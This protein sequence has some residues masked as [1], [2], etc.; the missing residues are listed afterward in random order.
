VRIGLLSTP[1]VPV[2]P[3][4]YG[5]TEMV[6]GFLARGLV[7]AGHEVVV[8]GHRESAIRGV[9][10]IPAPAVPDGVTIGQVS[11]E[12]AHVLWGYR[13]LLAA[14]VDLIHDHTTAGPV[15]GARLA[16]DAGVPV[17][18]T[19]HGPFDW[20]ARELYTQA[21][22]IC[23]VVAIS[24]G[25]AIG[26]RS[27]PVSAIIHHG[28]DVEDVPVGDGSGGYL[29][30]LGRLNADKGVAR[31]A[32]LARAAGMPLRIAA[33]M[34][35]PEERDYFQKEVEPLLGDGITYVGELGGRDKYD[36]VGAAVALFNPID[37]DEPFGMSMIESLATGTPVIATPR[38]S[39]PEIV[40]DGS[41]GRFGT[42]DAELIAAVR[43]AHELD[44]AACRRAAEERFSTRRMTDD[45]LAL[46]RTVVRPK[47]T[48][49]RGTGQLAAPA[50][51]ARRGP[52]SVAAG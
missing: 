3:P 33:K 20:R 19:N 13:Q 45:H 35:E 38:G 36:F 12:L 10:L 25:Q 42:S 52:D 16:H 23:S 22:P 40:D 41:T 46:Y 48:A 30:F 1:W 4:N 17:V 47:L 6:V 29:A 8:V 44:R 39:V 37:W 15:T 49:V 18:A 5:G 2:P 51:V 24:A 32:R 7:R 27:T 26:A 21:S 28:I 43:T 50:P 11:V 9:R 31:A 14:G 34:W